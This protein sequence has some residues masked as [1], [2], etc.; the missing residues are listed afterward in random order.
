ML[1]GVGGAPS[2]G[3][4]YPDMWSYLCLLNSRIFSIRS[5][6]SCLRCSPIVALSL[7]YKGTVENK[8]HSICRDYSNTLAKLVL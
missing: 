8:A 4:P 2:D 7:V 5:R 1:R 3:R 6:A